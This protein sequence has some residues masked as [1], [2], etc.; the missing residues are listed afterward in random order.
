MY[1]S[2]HL[3]STISISLLALTGCATSI[4]KPT[5]ANLQRE[6]IQKQVNLAAQA[7]QICINQISTTNDYQTVINQVIVETE[8]SENRFDLMNKK[9]RINQSQKKSLS[10][11]LQDTTKCN[12]IHL[13]SLAGSPYLNTYENY[14]SQLDRIYAELLDGQITIGIANTRKLDLIDLRRNQHSQVTT[15][16]TDALQRMHTQEMKTREADSQA[17]RAR[18]A[19]ALQSMSN[20]FGATSQYY[21]NQNQ[22]IQQNNQYQYR[23]PTNTTCQPNGV[24]GF[25]CTTR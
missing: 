2:K 15:A 6:E 4:P 20:S 21:Q 18:W 23:P 8:T 1:M 17:N 9:N 19:A 22:Q 24:G 5:Q 16:L 25:N 14:Y 13:Q 12:Q 3:L 10:V 7:N 11:F